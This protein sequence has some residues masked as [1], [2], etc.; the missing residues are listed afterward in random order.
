MCT[1]VPC[2]NTGNR[3]IKVGFHFRNC[4]QCIS[5]MEYFIGD[6]QKVDRVANT[7]R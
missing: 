2:I 6:V 1:D 7:K 4:V 5:G 3:E